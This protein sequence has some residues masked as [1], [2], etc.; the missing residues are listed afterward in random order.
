VLVDSRSSP[1]AGCGRSQGHHRSPGAADSR[2][3]KIAGSSPITGHWRIAGSSPICGALSRCLP[4][5]RRPTV[6]T[7]DSIGRFPRVRLPT[8][9]RRR[10]L[11]TSRHRSNHCNPKS[12]RQ[13]DSATTAWPPTVHNLA[14][15]ASEVARWSKPLKFPQIFNADDSSVSE[16]NAASEIFLQIICA[17][18]EKIGG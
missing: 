14:H 1:I 5:S 18:R 13:K 17:R 11:A 16:P 10:S 2:L 6:P 3:R 15:H 12:S 8:T 7:D 9:P 4:A